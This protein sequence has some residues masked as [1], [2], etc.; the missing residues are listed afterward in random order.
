[1]N[2]NA[3]NWSC[4][5]CARVVRFMGGLCVLVVVPGVVRGLCADCPGVPPVRTEACRYFSSTFLMT[6]YYALALHLTYFYFYSLLLLLLPI[7]T[8]YYS[9]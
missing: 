8:P 1:M 9:L 7:T 5:R 4:G 6:S 2:L 3:R